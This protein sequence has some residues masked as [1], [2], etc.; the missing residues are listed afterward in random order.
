MAAFMWIL[1]YAKCLYDIAD[2]YLDSLVITN[3]WLV[4]FRRNWLFSYTTDYLQ[5]VSVE[6]IS[7]EQTSFRDTLFKKWDL[8]VRLED[9]KYIFKEVGHPAL[10]VNKLLHRKEKILWRY[11]YHENETQTEVDTKD[12]YELLVEALGEVVTEYVEKKKETY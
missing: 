3:R 6:S 5:R 2:E 8:K 12:K 9:E 11:Q 7:E 4:L 1:I 10:Q